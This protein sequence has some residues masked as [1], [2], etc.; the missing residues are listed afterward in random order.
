M[1]LKQTIKAVISGIV[2]SGVGMGMPA[3]GHPILPAVMGVES[4]RL[5]PQQQTVRGV[6]KS[7]LDGSPLLGVSVAI[8]GTSR[9]VSTN[10][11]GGFILENVDGDA[12]LVFTMVGHSTMEVPL[13][14]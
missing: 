9:G 7:S 11:E 1:N 2:V 3:T 4:P 10:E 12:V 14:N 5:V 6:V 13:N 8:K